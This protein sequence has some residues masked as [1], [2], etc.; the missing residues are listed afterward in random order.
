[1]SAADTAS[2]SVCYTPSDAI[3][4]LE[5]LQSHM[6]T[7]Y[8]WT[9]QIQLQ[10]NF[11]GIST[12]QTFARA[13]HRS[14]T[15]SPSLQDQYIRLLR[16][17]ELRAGPYSG[18]NT[19]APIVK[20]GA[21]RITTL[22]SKRTEPGEHRRP[23]RNGGSVGVCF[24]KCCRELERR[25]EMIGVSLNEAAGVDEEGDSLRANSSQESTSP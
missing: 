3:R 9:D 2:D 25:C 11:V 21:S 17:V 6:L 19:L 4:D 22:I 12:L 24:T 8:G 1:M 7:Q 18:Y 13:Y 5:I 16:L 10:E 20:Q 14:R 23:A 15:H